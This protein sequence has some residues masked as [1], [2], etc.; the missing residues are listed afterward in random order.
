MSPDNVFAERSRVAESVLRKY[1]LG[2]TVPGMEN[3]VSIARAA[4]VN[5]KWLATGEGPKPGM[6]INIDLLVFL[7]AACAEYER[8]LNVPLSYA[9]KAFLISAIY[10]RWWQDGVEVIGLGEFIKADIEALH[11]SMKKNEE[12]LRYRLSQLWDR[13]YADAIMEMRSR[14]KCLRGALKKKKKEVRP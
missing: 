5:I 12:L 4:G 13:E 9:E 3:L 2:P 7:L 14:S 1:L 8:A 6:E 10:N 11:L